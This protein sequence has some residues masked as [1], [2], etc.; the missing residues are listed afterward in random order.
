[1][2]DDYKKEKMN[3]DYKFPLKDVSDIST[4][5]DFLPSQ[6]LA[7]YI[8]YNPKV[9]G[10]L[11]KK[12]IHL[13][14]Y[15]MVCAVYYLVEVILAFTLFPGNNLKNFYFQTQWGLF[16]TAVYF[17]MIASWPVKTHQTTKMPEFFK[18]LNIMIL[19]VEYMITLF[20]FTILQPGFLHKWDTQHN[21]YLKWGMFAWHILPTLTLSIDTAWNKNVFTKKDVLFPL[22]FGTIYQIWNA[23][24][25]IFFEVT[26]YQVINYKSWMTLVYILLAAALITGFSFLMVC[27]KNWHFQRRKKSN[28]LITDKTFEKEDSLDTGASILP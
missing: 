26:P 3:D 22:A 21:T 2:N 24:L 11:F 9:H 4:A 28:K 25:G 16:T 8:K 15:R 19:S 7:L 20:F 10:V 12:P 6:N 5:S 18:A 13:F 27:M 17:I 23:I 14:Y 1:M